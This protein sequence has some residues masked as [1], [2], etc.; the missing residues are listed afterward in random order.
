VSTDFLQVRL[1]GHRFDEHTVPF[2]VLRDF[3]GLEELLVELARRIHLKAHPERQRAARGLR[4]H[5]QI[6]LA[7]VTDGSA[8]LKIVR[9]S[10]GELPLEDVF[11]KARDL[12]LAAMCAAFLNQAAPADF[13]FDLYPYFERF[14]K[15]LKADEGVEFPAEEA[16]PA[17]TYDQKLRRH[18]ILRSGAKSYTEPV[19][20]R[21]SIVEV[22]DQLSSFTLRLPDGKMHRAIYKPAW[23]TTVIK[24]LDERASTRILLQA[25]GV[26]DGAEQLTR[27]QDL[28]SIDLL[29]SND[30]DMRI[31]ELLTIKDGW[32]DGAGTAPSRDGLEWLRKEFT[33]HW[34]DD[35]ALPFLYPTPDGGIRAE[36]SST[37]CEI[38]AEIDLGT[39]QAEFFSTPLND[40]EGEEITVPLTTPAEWRTASEWVAK[41]TPM[42]PEVTGGIA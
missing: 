21:G 10:H 3:V 30:L 9:L 28:T 34:S 8:K 13:P 23:R 26:F 36:W 42:E 11:D 18:L 1:V 5:F 33:E 32:L 40:G 4:E 29:D 37:D 19:E 25:T 20:L 15:S 17:F 6:G 31:D 2:E 38:S 24:A 39:K 14:G 16:R 41:F 27:I 7:Q 12:A 35:V 22:N